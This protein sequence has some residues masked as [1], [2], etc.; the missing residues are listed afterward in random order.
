[1]VALLFMKVKLLKKTV[2]L[3]KMLSQEVK[4]LH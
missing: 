2:R 1:M 3:V 4:N